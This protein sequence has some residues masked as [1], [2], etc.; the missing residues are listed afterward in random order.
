MF[1]CFKHASHLGVASDFVHDQVE[2]LQ[3]TKRQQLLFHLHVRQTL[4]RQP[5]SAGN[6]ADHASALLHHDSDVQS[7]STQ[8]AGNHL[9]SFT[10]LLFVGFSVLPLM[11]QARA[12]HQA[13]TPSF[14]ALLPDAMLSSD[15][16]WDRHH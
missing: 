8:L 15:L 12:C 10:R 7:K 2:S 1:F 6:G 3:D 11:P 16:V 4:S 14:T 9:T 5:C 13:A